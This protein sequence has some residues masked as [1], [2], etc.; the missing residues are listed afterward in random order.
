MTVASG[1]RRRVGQ[2]ARTTGRSSGVDGQALQVRERRVADAEVVDGDAHA[3]VAAARAASRRCLRVLHGAALRDLE[4]Q[5]C[6]ASPVS[7]QRALHVATRSG[8]WNW[9]AER[10]TATRRPGWPE[11][12]PGSRLAAGRAQHQGADGHDEARHLGQAMNSARPTARAPPGSA[13]AAAPRPRRRGRVARSQQGL[14]VDAQ[15]ARAARAGGRL[16]SRPGAPPRR[17]HARAA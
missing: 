9:R 5:R 10:F 2:A 12:L 3:Q 13:S 1:R 8:C 11:S 15:L 4:L 17:V 6:G 7:A 16:F 14:V